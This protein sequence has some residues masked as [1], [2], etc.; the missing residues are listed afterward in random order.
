MKKTA[1]FAIILVMIAA[2]FGSAS[3]DYLDQKEE[4]DLHYRKFESNYLKKADQNLSDGRYWLTSED[5]RTLLAVTLYM[6]CY[7]G[8]I[9]N[10]DIEGVELSNLIDLCAAEDSIYVTINWK[11]EKHQA[12]LYKLNAYSIAE[13]AS[14]TAVYDTETQTIEYTRGHGKKSNIIVD[15]HHVEADM[16]YDTLSSIIGEDD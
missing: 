7:F 16:F 11:D 3:A 8:M 5:T 13:M 10:L 4:T 9:S 12:M 15:A 1:V 2:M 14:V 6:D